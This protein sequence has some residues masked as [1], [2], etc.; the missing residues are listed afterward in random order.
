MMMNKRA[1]LPPFMRPISRF[2]SR[3]PHPGSAV[4]TT[5]LNVA[6]RRALPQDVYL[7]LIGRH[8]EIVVSDWGAR[9][10][11]AVTPD[12]FVP[13]PQSAAIDLSIMA[14]ARDFALLASGDEDADTLYFDRRVVVEGDT[15]LALLIKNTLDALPAP[16]LRKFIR[17]LHHGMSR[18]RLLRVRHGI[19][20]RPSTS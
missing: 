2:M 10:R 9:F 7:Q 8:A 15:E 6:L 1:S 14:T 17:T 11:F 19:F 16:K 12:R 3:L 4:F 18:L 13:L 5:V 20:N